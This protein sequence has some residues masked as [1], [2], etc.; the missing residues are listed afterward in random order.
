MG[1]RV[2]AVFCGEGE[3]GRERGVVWQCGLGDK[4]AAACWSGV[5]GGSVGGGLV[6]G[7]RVGHGLGGDGLGV[8]NEDGWEW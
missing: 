6:L 2:N 8:G 4:A 3:P 5:V 7:F 1:W